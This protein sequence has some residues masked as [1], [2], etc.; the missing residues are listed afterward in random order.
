MKSNAP[1]PQAP[2]VSPTVPCPPTYHRHCCPLHGLLV[3][4]GRL[5]PGRGACRGQQRATINLLPLL[6]LDPPPR[7]RASVVVFL[8]LLFPQSPGLCTTRLLFISPPVGEASELIAVSRRGFGGV[9]RLATYHASS[10]RRAGRSAG[11]LGWLCIAT[12]N[13]G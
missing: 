7:R 9:G 11:G 2:S 6:T 13:R 3:H 8:L 12:N 10:R 5:A 4:R 1:C